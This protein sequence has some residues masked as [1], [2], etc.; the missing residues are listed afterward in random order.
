[1]RG[2]LAFSVFRREEIVKVQGVLIEHEVLEEKRM[3]GL[4]IITG[5]RL[6]LTV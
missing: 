5:N 1:M 3:H 6:F 2:F 4:E